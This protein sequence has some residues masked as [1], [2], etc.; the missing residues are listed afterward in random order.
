MTFVAS[1]HSPQFS[2]LDLLINPDVFPSL[3]IGSLVAI[4]PSPHGPEVVTMV[5][6]TEKTKGAS[7]LSLKSALADLARI[8]PRQE[9]LLREIRPGEFDALTIE[10][11]V[12]EQFLA[13]D[14]QWRVKRSM[15]GRTV[16][17][18]K[19]FLGAGVRCVVRAV[20]RREPGRPPMQQTSGVVVE[21]T[22]VLFR[23]RT[24]RVFYLMQ[25]SR[26]MWDFAEDGTSTYVEKAL[27][28]FRELFDRWHRASATHLFTL[29]FFQRTLF[30]PGSETASAEAQRAGSTIR[31]GPDGSF[32]EDKYKV[33]FD[34]E[35]PTA[36]DRSKI[37]QR[38]KIAF[39]Q[40]A[41]SA[42]SP[43]GT[44]SSAARGNVLEALNLALG[45]CERGH[46]NRSLH[47][48]ENVVNVISPG[49]GFIDGVGKELLAITKQRMVAVGIQCQYISL[50]KTPLHK[51]PLVRTVEG[52]LSFPAWVRVSFFM[53]AHQ[54]SFAP[55]LC[56]TSRSELLSSVI[57]ICQATGVQGQARIPLSSA[58]SVNAALGVVG[59]ALPPLPEDVDEDDFDSRAFA[60]PAA[61]GGGGGA[62]DSK[63]R[64]GHPPLGHAH[65]HARDA[66]AHHQ[67]HH[68]LADDAAGRSTTEGSPAARHNLPPASTSS[69]RRFS[70]A[71]QRR[72]TPE[73]PALSAL[74]VAMRLSKDGASASGGGG[75]DAGSARRNSYSHTEPSGTAHSGRPSALS[76]AMSSHA[77]STSHMGS[78]VDAGSAY[79]SLPVE[80]LLQRGKAEGPAGARATSGPIAID[81]KRSA[82]ALSLA[83]SPSISRSLSL[84]ARSFQR[85]ATATDADSASPPSSPTRILKNPPLEN[86]SSTA[87]TTAKGGR[88][89]AAPSAAASALA[90]LTLSSSSSLSLPPGVQQQQQ[91]SSTP[92]PSLWIKAPHAVV[93][94]SQQHLVSTT[95]PPSAPVAPPR[96]ALTWPPS[97]NPFVLDGSLAPQSA[98]Q[99]SSAKER[100]WAHGPVDSSRS[101]QDMSV[102]W[103]DLCEPVCLPLTTD[104]FPSPS[105]LNSNSAVREYVVSFSNLAADVLEDLMEELISQRLNHGFQIFADNDLLNQGGAAA[106]QQAA[107]RE[108]SVGPESRT[109]SGARGGSV[110]SFPPPK[111]ANNNPLL[112]AAAA[113]GSPGAPGPAP[114]TTATPS[115]PAAGGKDEQP[116]GAQAPGAARS[117]LMV[118]RPKTGAQAPL[119]KAGSV[120]S[121]AQ[122]ASNSALQ[123][124]E[125]RR[126]HLLN[127]KHRFVL[128]HHVHILEYDASGPHI[129]VQRYR[130]E[131]EAQLP[132][133]SYTYKLWPLGL[134]RF[135]HRSASIAHEAETSFRWPALDD[136]LCGNVE[137]I[138]DVEPFR[139]NRVMACLLPVQGAPPATESHWIRFKGAM[140]PNAGADVTAPEDQK[141][142]VVRTR[143]VI[144]GTSVPSV[145]AGAG[146]GGAT[147]GVGGVG[148]GAG[149]LMSTS[150]FNLGGSLAGTLPASAASSAS[151]A[152]LLGLGAAPGASAAA[153]SNPVLAGGA[154]PATPA[155]GASVGSSV[156]SNLQATLPLLQRPQDTLIVSY[157]SEFVPMEPYRIEIDWLTCGAQAADDYIQRLLRRAKQ[158]N[159]H[160]ALI[161]RLEWLNNHPFRT[162]RKFD[163]SALPAAEQEAFAAEVERLLTGKYDFYRVKSSRGAKKQA[164]QLIHATGSSFVRIDQAGYV[165]WILNEMTAMRQYVKG[166]V[167]LFGT[168]FAE[169][170]DLLEAKLKE[171]RK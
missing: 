106:R 15:I 14:A 86:S 116:A 104:F 107:Q 93:P 118:R 54:N 143:L 153:L 94:A 144:G 23:S 110:L 6:S 3:T 98:K 156:T 9:V 171:G 146:G 149:A 164:Y 39:A 161:P 96:P 20:V 163:Y 11:A 21:G 120:V 81:D 159:L 103:Q 1:V 121:A 97:K 33:V 160:F 2:D 12:K 145:L 13:R 56:P 142:G 71:Q 130:R 136:M 62:E 50:S 99:R 100:Q 131:R 158:L 80:D 140:L 115:T 126:N 138:R 49:R 22:R 88:A 4:S 63:E 113:A 46:L 108:G 42:R 32:Y 41:E 69:S 154:P 129:S 162:V 101:A 5:T 111:P 10:L 141:D 168:F 139:F 92:T 34:N 37:L 27:R 60:V 55:V 82:K 95:L 18:G 45:I 134:K 29:V 85:R 74:S 165:A 43:T 150:S 64:G 169:A 26:E 123:A 75:G 31:Q 83:S 38:I 170:S 91:P 36:A 72:D 40:F 119:R 105:A 79:L 84:A 58:I 112:A 8:H 59:L 73:P 78:S 67:A 90:A 102:P 132:T 147:G 155:M 117:S 30:S 57:P 89:A 24:A 19:D 128:G 127:T 35:T 148:G 48:T 157:H 124:R 52:G 25:C 7:V 28:F 151:S 51:V 68:H 167:D 70:A 76:S 65:A 109:P 166:A 122:S 16:F 47:A 66:H 61:G 17:V 152:S 125:A 133:L 77:G 135:F 53:D 114:P 44:P 87:I 137:D